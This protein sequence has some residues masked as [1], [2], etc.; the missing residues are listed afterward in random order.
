MIS[1][2]LTN[3]DSSQ[4]Y[5]DVLYD[6]VLVEKT[7]MPIIHNDIEL[8][9]SEAQQ[10]I[11]ERHNNPPLVLDK[12]EKQKAWK[13]KLDAGYQSPALNLTMSLTNSI[14]DNEDVF[15]KAQKL[16][17]VLKNSV[18][19]QLQSAGMTEQMIDNYEIDIRDKDG[20]KHKR[21]ISQALDYITEM[22]K[23]GLKINE[24][25]GLLFDAETQEDLDAIDITFD[26][27]MIV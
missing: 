21:S 10:I 4:Y 5:Y 2:I 1:V 14:I 9:S 12:S 15:L 11:L 8:T 3:T 20:V 7:S 23:I 19:P 27:S 24:I 18:I 25:N 16:E 17:F 22:T 26:W 6:N 13:Q